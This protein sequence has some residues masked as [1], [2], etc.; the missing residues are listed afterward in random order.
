MHAILKT[1]F[2]P[3]VLLFS[4]LVMSDSLQLHE[5]TGSSV[6]EIFQVRILDCVAIT[7][8]RGSS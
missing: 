1:Q 4:H 6:H 8:S 2:L 5:V 7:F 3:L